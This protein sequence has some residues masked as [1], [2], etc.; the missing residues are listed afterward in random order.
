VASFRT[1]GQIGV[2][3]GERGQVGYAP[4]MPP[5]VY[6]EGAALFIPAGSK[7]VFQVHYTPNGSPQKDRSYIGLKFADPKDVKE[8]IGG[9]MIAQIKL[10]IPPGD[11][12]Y[13]AQSV[14]TFNTPARLIT[15]TPHMHL[16]GKSFRYEAEYPNGQREILL[17]IP[18]Y[19]FNWQ[20]RYDL[21]E[22]KLMPKGT[23][24]TCTAHYDNSEENL[25]NPN[26]KATVRWGD[27]TWDE[28]MI[29]YFTSLPVEGE[30]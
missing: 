27:Q 7:L 30:R 12:N 11:D 23:R 22:P 6:P 4:G 28:M 26:P 1:G 16:R 24:L 20:L 18:R 3:V 9:G 10:A 29:G 25:S 17:D 2:R 19:D 21:A 14:H 13:E 8:K 15:L 5:A